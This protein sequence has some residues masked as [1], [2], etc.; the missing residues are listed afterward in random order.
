MFLRRPWSGV[1][2]LFL[3]IL[4]CATKNAASPVFLSV[5]LTGAARYR[6]LPPQDIETPLDM[7]QRVF[8]AWGKQEFVFD[9]WVQADAAHIHMT[10]MNSFGAGMG[11][12]LFSGEGLS[13]TSTVFPSSLKPEYIAADFQFCFYRA[14]TLARALKDAGLDLEISRP[15]DAVEVRV[16]R[17]GDQRIIEIEKTRGAVRYTNYLRG[18]SYTLRGEFP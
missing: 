6:L 16:I 15:N 17:E 1:F 7:A 13:L 9:S 4:S 14:D 10:F 18:Y 8:G 11:D 12:L 5:Y 2:F 3:C